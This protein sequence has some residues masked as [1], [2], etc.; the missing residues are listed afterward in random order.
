MTKFAFL[1]LAV[2]LLG[3]QAEARIGDNLKIAGTSATVYSGPNVSSTKV[4]TA[5]GKMKLIEMERQAGWVLVTVRPSGVQGWV[6]EKELRIASSQ[7][8]V[9]SSPASARKALNALGPVRTITLDDMGFKKGHIFRGS[10]SGHSQD[11]YFE[12]PMDSSVRGGVFRISYRASNMLHSLSNIRVFANDVPLAQ[13]NAI[14]DGLVHEMAIVLPGSMFRDG[15]VKISVES[16]TLVDENRCLDIRSGG[17]FLH[18]LPSSALDITYSSID[19]SIRDAWRMLPHKVTVTLPAGKLEASQFAAAM[20]V[21][22]LLANS[23]REVMI[24]RMPEMGDVVIAQKGEIVSVLNQRGKQLTKGFVELKSNDVF[25]TPADNIN[26]IKSGN[27]VSVAVSEPYDV[28]PLYLV[29]ERWELLTAGRHYD[30]NRPDRFYSLR[31][32]PKDSGSDHFSLPLYQLDTS[33]HYVATETVWATT[34]SPR[35]LP[36]GTRL[37]MLSLSIIAPVRWEADPTYELYAFLNDV[38]VFSKRLENDGLKHNYSVPLPVEYQQQYNNLRFV[39]QHDVV[40]GDCYGIMPTDFVQITPDT[41]IIVKKTDEEP[42]KFSGLS[43]YFSSGFDMFIADKYLS[44]PENAL[45]LISRVAADLPI[46][47]DYSKIRFLKES[48]QLDP[49]GPFVAFGNFNQEGLNAPLRT[50]QGK[51]EIRDRDG[52]SFF[53]VNALPNITI[54][55]IV[56][57]SSGHGLLVIPS[58]QI[59]HD[60]SKKLRLIEGDVAF[61]DTHGVLLNVDSKQPTLAEV[62]YPDTKDWFAVLGEYRF[63]LLGLLWFLLSL[64]IVYVFRMTRRQQVED[65]DVEMPTSDDLHSQRAHHTNINIEDD[66]LPSSSK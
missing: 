37:D 10:Q 63:W 65:H 48:D 38:L 45:Y 24:K 19:R 40:S 14:S 21:M 53:S 56:G 23:G 6:R 16:G 8:E 5:D 61:I 9:A 46:V 42:K 31:A 43:Q 55:E 49:N 3:A 47:M 36:S 7:S 58:D 4:L 60:F 13:A 50:D 44:N 35:D 59:M 54:A 22:E 32:L 33:P 57:D 66:D 12:T 2:L 15:M 41:S 18:I 20:S 64:A 11:F 26:L 34:L 1:A 27:S 25:Q 62:Y 51:V 28:Q 17:G 52:Q 30:I 39:V 29:D